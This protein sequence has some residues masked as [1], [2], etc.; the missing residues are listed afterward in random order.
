MSDISRSR[1]IQPPLI[2]EEA[3]QAEPH[4]G[5]PPP[6]RGNTPRHLARFAIACRA[7]AIILARQKFHSE[8]D[9]LRRLAASADLV[10][11]T[12]SYGYRHYE[13]SGGPSG[14]VSTSKQV[15][16]PQRGHPTPV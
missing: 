4:V 3:T 8:A 5:Q 1:G 13:Y 10:A 12:T 2:E 16:T 11:H 7:S 14:N 6:L 9:N 15:E